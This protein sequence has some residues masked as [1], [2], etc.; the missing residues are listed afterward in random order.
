MTLSIRKKLL[1]SSLLLLFIPWFGYQSIQNIENDLRREQ[2]EQLLNRAKLVSVVLQ[3]QASLFSSEK[4]LIAHEN[5]NHVY[6]RQLNSAIQ[7][8]GYTNDWA[9][10]DDRFR[11]YRNNKYNKNII[12]DTLSF[13]H[14]VGNYKRYLYA[15]FKVSDDKIVY[16]RPGSFRLKNSD[17]LRINMIDNKGDLQQYI[18]TTQ[19]PGW[20]TAHKLMRD[21]Q[22]LPQVK[23]KGEWQETESGYNIE[24]RIPLNMLG[25]MISFAIA[26][27]DDED[28]REITQIIGTADAS[29]P[30]ALAS[31]IVPSPVVESLLK[32]IHQGVSRT[33]VIDN[34]YRVIAVVGSLKKNLYQTNDDEQAIEKTE[35]TSSIFQSIMR[36][37]YQLLLHQP[38]SY[39]KDDLSSASVLTGDEFKTALSGQPATQWR[40]TPD[41]QVNILTVTHPITI[42]NQVVGAIAIEETNTSILILQNRA[43]EILINLS[44]LAFVIA[45]SV[46]ILFASRLSN[47]IRR[48]RNDADQA[49]ASDGRVKGGM[50]ATK[51]TDEIG[52][53]SRSFSDMLTRLTQYNRYL[54]TM[55]SKLSHELRTPIT[56]VRS[57][58]DNLEL[59]NTSSDSAIILQRAREGLNRLSNILTRMSEATRLEQTLHNEEKIL[60]K[61]DDVIRSCIDGYRSANPN[62]QFDFQASHEDFSLSGVPEFIA[63]LLDK[64]IGNAIDFHQTGSTISVSIKKYDNYISLNISNIGSRLPSNMQNNLFDSMV[65]VRDAQSTETHLGLGLYIVRLIAQFHQADVIANNLDDDSGVEFKVQFP[66]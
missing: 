25:N 6:V 53:L 23:I 66:V 3:E 59:K 13:Q 17:H 44:I 51:S 57:S 24:I 27:V 37:F 58:L 54:E 22:P 9:M 36:L 5:I 28:V 61:L 11:L 32:K 45:S 65:S 16:R 20:V 19:T 35:R 42:N 56:V 60:F 34:N 46:L 7:L 38:S 63:Q 1:L 41:T 39:F 10:Y 62:I 64:L 26:D 49:I 21:Q 40:T 8:D 50:K 43:F 52:D 15:I 29:N 14:Q 4:N 47:R 33:W 2:Q 31:I 18:I 30:F 55:A 12:T 48:L